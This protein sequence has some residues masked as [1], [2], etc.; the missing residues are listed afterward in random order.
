MGQSW[1]VQPK[2]QGRESLP[3]AQA[4]S[5]PFRD[6]LDQWRA[7]P[8]GCV[9]AETFSERSRLRT[10]EALDE[11]MH[12][13][14]HTAGTK[15]TL[16]LGLQDTLRSVVGSFEIPTGLSGWLQASCRAI[17][18]SARS[19]PR[20]CRRGPSP[21]LLSPPAPERD[22][23]TF[24]PYHGP[25]DGFSHEGHVFGNQQQPNR[26]QLDAKHWKKPEQ[27]TDDKEHA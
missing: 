10:P 24:E 11:W 23:L 19:R 12:P 16:K 5:K 14:P 26:Q 3:F 7:V 22:P 27:A 17:F 25:G 13:V 20:P 21:A 1:L 15:N 4:M 6:A 9:H 2:S 8:P 18:A